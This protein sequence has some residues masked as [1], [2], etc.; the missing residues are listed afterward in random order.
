ME[1]RFPPH[2]D[3]DQSVESWAGFPGLNNDLS[4]TREDILIGSCVLV[5]YS[6]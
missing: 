1:L 3:P 2:K 6:G 4:K 5:A